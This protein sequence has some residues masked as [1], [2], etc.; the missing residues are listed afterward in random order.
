[1]GVSGCICVGGSQVQPV[2]EEL[3]TPIADH[4]LQ[5]IRAGFEPWRV[6]RFR[7]TVPRNT[8]LR[9]VG[10]SARWPRLGSRLETGAKWAQSAT[11]CLSRRVFRPTGFTSCVDR[12]F[13]NEF[14]LAVDTPEAGISSLPGNRVA[15]LP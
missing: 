9:F 13:Q 5:S 7:R 8:G 10:V 6:A 15:I 1:M 3:G 2:G 4:V 11:K 14:Y 12:S